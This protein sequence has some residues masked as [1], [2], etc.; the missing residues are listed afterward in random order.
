M[1]KLIKSSKL[2]LLEIYEILIIINNN[3]LLVIFGN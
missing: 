3:R 1:K 2:D